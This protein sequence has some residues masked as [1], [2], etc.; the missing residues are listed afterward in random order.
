MSRKE[1]QVRNSTLGQVFLLRAALEPVYDEPQQRTSMGTYPEVKDVCDSM[2]W[3]LCGSERGCSGD[4]DNSGGSRAYTALLFG[5]YPKGSTLA[6]RGTKNV[7]ERTVAHPQG[8]CTSHPEVPSTS[9]IPNTVTQVIP[10]SP[11]GV[12]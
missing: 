2:E 8:A 7:L 10:D 6:A 3:A 1:G 5:I 11:L 9:N 4:S 12:L